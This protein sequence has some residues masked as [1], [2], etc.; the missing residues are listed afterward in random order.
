MR[1]FSKT[2][3]RLL[4]V[5]VVLYT[6]LYFCRLNLSAVLDAITRD[7]NISI[8]SAG[9]LQTVF[10]LLPLPGLDGGRMVRNIC[11]KMRRFGVQ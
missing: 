7:L 6:V 5:C 9:L 1:H 3:L 8:A 2:Q 11:C 4:T 10:I